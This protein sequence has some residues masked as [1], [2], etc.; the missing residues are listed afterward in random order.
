MATTTQ[1]THRAV[2]VLNLPKRMPALITYAQGI[3]TA[4]TNNAFFPNPTPTPA[5]INAAIAQLQ[6]AE[7]AALS[8][9]KGAVTVRNDKRVAL[10][11]LLQELKG[12]VQ[13]TADANVE[14]GAA[15]I[16]S[17]AIS[18]KKTSVR[19]PRVFT[20]EQ[21]EVSGSAKLFAV[22]AGARSS[23]EWE[24]SAD[25]GKTWVTAPV[26]LQASTT[27]PGLTPGSTVQF[28][29][30]PVTKAGE[31]NWSQTVSLILK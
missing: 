8:R 30:R 24:Y 14:N 27:V 29:Y 20:A 9:V 28:R 16:E 1:S 15:I 21:A 26:T 12:N 3:A 7:T 17:A 19:K 10:V 6:T 11:A 25:G 13:T 18:V 5:A 2:A 4:L 23:Y 31:G 22:S